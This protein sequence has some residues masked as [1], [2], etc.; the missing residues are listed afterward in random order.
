[1]KITDMNAGTKLE[2]ELL[3]DNGTKT[4]CLLVSEFEWS[5]GNDIA[6]IAAPIQEGDYYPIRPGTSMSI[7]FS[8]KA[9]FYRFSASLTDKSVKGNLP[10][11]KIKVTSDF[12]RIQRR[13]FFRFE[14][15]LPV[16]YRTVDSENALRNIKT[17]FAD[18]ITRDLSG[19]G[20]CIAL[21]E[22]VEKDIII[23][24]ELSIP[25]FN[26]IA[27]LG[28]VKRLSPCEAKGIYKYEIGVEFIKIDNKDREAI[29]G[30]IFK[31]Q[32]KLRKKGLV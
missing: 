6:F 22:K 4:E 7:F 13:Q 23:E 28:K 26:T 27:F 25:E 5:E 9:E 12:E 29:I 30:Y 17:P 21:K 15:I 19:G 3:D 10:L 18:T 16:K 14:C 1:M 2:L 8:N 31:E 11:L 24:C 20:A 32:R